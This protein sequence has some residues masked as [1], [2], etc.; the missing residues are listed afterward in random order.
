M[1]EDAA[2]TVHIA[3][4]AGPLIPIPQ[5][6]I[7]SLYNRYQNV[8]GQSTRR[9]TGCRRAPMSADAI[10]AG[11]TSLGI[12]L[13]S[14]RIKAC[15]IGEETAAVL[16]VGSHDWENRFE[17]RVWTYSLE[18]VWSGMQVRLWRP[19]RRCRAALRRAPRDDRR[20]RRLG[21]DA[22][23]SRLRR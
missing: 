4:E 11:R 14:T 9:P 16:A 12:E 23:V 6:R 3:R 22:R 15:L 13:G 19:D 18:D 5:E 10:V 1:C 17:G 21:D 7:D 20:D 8:Y 2:R